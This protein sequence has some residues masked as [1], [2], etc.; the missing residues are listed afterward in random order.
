VG[1]SFADSILLVDRIGVLLLLL[2]GPIE[3]QLMAVC[4]TLGGS[5]LFFYILSAEL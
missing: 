4:S 1:S 2:L 5:V 3:A